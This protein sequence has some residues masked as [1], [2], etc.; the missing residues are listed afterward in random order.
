MIASDVEQGG[1]STASVFDFLYND[2]RR[3]GS[4]LA[5]LDENG[6]LTEI[7]RGDQSSKRG[8]RGFTVGMQ[9]MGTGG[10]VERAP[11]E[12]GSESSERVYD[13]FWANARELLD[14]LDDHGMIQRDLSAAPIGGVVLLS[15][16]MRVIDLSLV[17]ALWELP[18]I[19]KMV[20]RGAQPKSSDGQPALNRQD[21][22]AQEAKQRSAPA[23]KTSME[24]S[25]ELM[26]EMLPVLPHTLS[27]IVGG[28]NGVSWATLREEHLIGTGSDL[29][30]KHGVVIPGE[31]QMLGIL[32]ARP[33]QGGQGD[34]EANNAINFADPDRLGAHSLVGQ[35]AGVM[36]PIFRI[37]LGRPGTHF[38]IT[39]VM[40][41]RQ[42]G[43]AGI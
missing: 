26:L 40:I 13:P 20:M 17:K 41:F 42:V 18:G 4:Y 30:L 29:I 6:L 21:R 39:P 2:S 10:S 28:T 33:D 12:A 8:K 23:G 9:V 27:V 14:A 1:Q 15:G 22:R 11:E 43:H 19:R 36:S 5:Q 3:V 16:Q 38:G 7:R 31:W 37:L 35:L 24:E 32:D 34:V 25:M